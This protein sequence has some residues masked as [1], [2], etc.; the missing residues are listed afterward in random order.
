MVMSLLLQTAWWYVVVVAVELWRSNAPIKTVCSLCRTTFA[1]L[2]PVDVTVDDLSRFVGDMDV[3]VIT[4]YKVKPRRSPWQ[5][6][7]GI[8]PAD[9]NTCRLF[10]AREDVDKVLNDEM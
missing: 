1:V 10:V 5:R 2:V 7:V 3:N 4:C 8:M 6:Q 9:R